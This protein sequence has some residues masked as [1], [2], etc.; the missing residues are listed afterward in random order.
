MAATLWILIRNERLD[1]ITTA[2]PDSLE[3]RNQEVRN[4]SK[5][6]GGLAYLCGAIGWTAYCSKFSWVVAPPPF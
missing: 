4:R 6:L 2:T 1:G 3:V 5:G